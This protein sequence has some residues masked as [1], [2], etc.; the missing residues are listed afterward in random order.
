MRRVS[1]PTESRT[2]FTITVSE[3]QERLRKT[4]ISYFHLPPLFY[5]RIL[6][7]VDTVVSVSQ[8]PN[9]PQAQAEAQLRGPLEGKRSGGKA[10]RVPAVVLPGPLNPSRVDNVS[11][12]FSTWTAH[13]RLAM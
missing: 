7:C 1:A 9:L 10:I 4:A 5:L 3:R 12:T 13:F 11:Y 2:S 8:G 6:K